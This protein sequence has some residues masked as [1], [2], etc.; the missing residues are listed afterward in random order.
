[1]TGLTG[2]GKTDKIVPGGRRSA[3]LAWGALFATVVLAPMLSGCSSG[4]RLKQGDPLFGEFPPKTN[5]A[6]PPKPA[7]NQAALPPYPEATATSSTAAVAIGDPLSGGRQLSIGD[8]SAGGWYG[9]NTQSATLT[10]NPGGNAGVIPLLRRPEPVF[11]ETTSGPGTP[12]TR[13]QGATPHFTQAGDYKQLQ[14]ELKARRVSWQRLESSP[15]GFRFTCAVPNP[16]SPEFQRVY[17]ATA[18]DAES[19]IQAVLNQIAKQ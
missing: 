4:N 19:A 5:G 18:R 6:A 9:K 10:S 2:S 16:Q 14:A 15:D 3:T 11:G 7:K 13:D 8:G 17:E 12:A 1:M